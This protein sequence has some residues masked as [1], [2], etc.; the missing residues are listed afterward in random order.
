MDIGNIEVSYPYPALCAPDFYVSV[1]Y[2]GKESED[3]PEEEW[4]DDSWT[5]E[6]LCFYNPL[7]WD[8]DI[9]RSMLM[10]AGTIECDLWVNDLAGY[11]DQR[12]TVFGPSELLRKFNGF[13]K[14]DAEHCSLGNVVLKMADW[15]MDAIGDCPY[16]HE[17]LRYLS[18]MVADVMVML[19]RCLKD[20]K[21]RFYTCLDV[22][23][24]SV[25]NVSV[26]NG[27]LK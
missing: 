21:C 5:V 13:L 6:F 24:R 2:D 26:D 22:K 14:H 1:N 23:D 16:D 17:R 11:M 15:L 9:S 18:E 12:F 20:A 19:A 8:D 3:V 25:R 7:E 10:V 27:T 4:D